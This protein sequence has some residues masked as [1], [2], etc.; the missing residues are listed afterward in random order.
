MFPEGRGERNNFEIYNILFLTRP[1]SSKKLSLTCWS[2]SE[3]KLLGERKHLTSAPFSHPVP[4]KGIGGV[5]EETVRSRDEVH[6]PGAQTYQKKYHIKRQKESSSPST[7]YHCIT[8][9][10]FTS[11]PFTQ[12]FMSTF[13]KKKKNYKAW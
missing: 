13:Q 12:H 3:P 8:K 9:V 2:L 1:V 4:P 6:S 11:V 7:K 10:L 5:G